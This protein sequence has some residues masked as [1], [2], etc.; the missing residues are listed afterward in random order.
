[1]NPK[2]KKNGDVKIS[3]YVKG[4]SFSYSVIKSDNTKSDVQPFFSK[5]SVNLKKSPHSL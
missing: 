4:M 2:Y 1:M 5:E 3:Y